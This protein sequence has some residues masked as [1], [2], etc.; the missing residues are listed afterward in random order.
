MRKFRVGAESE[1]Q[2]VGSSVGRRG[3]REQP[4]GRQLDPWDVPTAHKQK[5]KERLTRRQ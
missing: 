3:R 4:V 5:R 1:W 2:E